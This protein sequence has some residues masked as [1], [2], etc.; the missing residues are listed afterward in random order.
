M[1]EL[2]REYE[3]M[4]P[5]LVRYAQ[6]RGHDDPEAFV[7]EV[8]AHALRGHYADQGW[9]LS[10]WLD[11]IARN[12]MTDYWRTRHRDDAVT[13]GATI[14]RY[15][16]DHLDVRDAIRKLP[17]RWRLILWLRYWEDLPMSRASR[18]MGI[19]Q[20]AG[21]QTRNRAIAGLR[22]AMRGESCGD[23]D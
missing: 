7:Q 4:R 22:R 11:R 13:L 10:T 17:E 8:F 9:R 5:L 6:S 23:E 14:D 19:S 12:L 20:G 3:R 2:E 16:S 18:I 21:K 15:P 1:S